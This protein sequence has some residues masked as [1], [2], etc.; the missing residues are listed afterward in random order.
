MKAAGTQGTII[1][2]RSVQR[3]SRGLI[4]PVAMARHVGRVCLV[5]EFSRSLHSYHNPRL[6]QPSV[7]CAA[8]IAGSQYDTSKKQP[9]SCRSGR[10]LVV[11]D[12]SIPSGS[13]PGSTLSLVSPEISWGAAHPSHRVRTRLI[14]T[15]KK[16]PKWCHYKYAKVRR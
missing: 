3:S 13:T 14:N 8:Q 5:E 4:T 2:Y 1:P 11:L 6:P 10:S 16:I 9:N 12:K 15:H 7:G